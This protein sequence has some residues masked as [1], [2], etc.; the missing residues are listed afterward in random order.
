MLP[1]ECF[2]LFLRRELRELFELCFVLVLHRLR[3]IM[4]E[5]KARTARQNSEAD[6][7]QS[8][9]RTHTRFCRQTA[10]SK[11]ILFRFQNKFVVDL[12][13]WTKLR[14]SDHSF[15]AVTMIVQRDHLVLKSTGCYF[16]DKCVCPQKNQ[17]LYISKHLP[18]CFLLE[19]QHQ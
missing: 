11:N 19:G 15:V 6:G 17:L 8:N 1:K 16:R 12:P 13:N 3:K 14:E 7:R 18:S 2:R 4:S 9:T 10:M 5:T